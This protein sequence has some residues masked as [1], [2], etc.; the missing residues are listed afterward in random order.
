V[1][2]RHGLNVA[3]R[4]VR[5]DDG[6]GAGHNQ[7]DEEEPKGVGMSHSRDD[8]GLLPVNATHEV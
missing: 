3:M 5:V 8:D 1:A 6:T 2:A 4:S 7:G